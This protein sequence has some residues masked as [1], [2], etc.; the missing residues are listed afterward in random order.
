MVWSR[1][2][3]FASNQLPAGQR[4][5]GQSPHK[6][7]AGQGRREGPEDRDVGTTNTA[8]SAREGAPQ[9]KAGL[10]TR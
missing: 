4:F 6:L 1:R 9:L 2:N 10:M 7:S 3:R 5:K 8:E